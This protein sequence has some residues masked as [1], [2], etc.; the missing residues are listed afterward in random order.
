MS[1]KLYELTKIYSDSTRDA[2][3]A[4]DLLTCEDDYPEYDTPM[5]ETDACRPIL[6]K[7]CRGFGMDVGFGGSRI[8]PDAWAFDMPQPYTQVGIET[9]QLRGDCR[10]FPFLCDGALDYIYSSHLLEDFTYIELYSILHEWRRVLKPD[11]LLITNCP[12]QQK[13]LAHVD[14]HFTKTG[15]DINNLAHK[16][17]TFSLGTFWEVL[18]TTGEWDTVFCQPEFGVYSWLLVVRKV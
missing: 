3:E 14:A 8:V 16:E 12:D 10:E 7:F 11:G 1:D 4:R 13:F 5:S 2:V 6:S 18:R 17:D 9:Q 15:E